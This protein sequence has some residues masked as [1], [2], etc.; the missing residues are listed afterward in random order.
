M[1]MNILAFPC[2][3]TSLLLSSSLALLQGNINQISK[4]P[5]LNLLLCLVHLPP[6]LHSLTLCTWSRILPQLQI[7]ICPDLSISASN[8]NRKKKFKKNLKKA[9]LQIIGNPEVWYGK[10]EIG[11]GKM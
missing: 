2:F 3:N 6:P 9:I 5:A 8:P 11:K 7:L 1:I 4:N 10:A